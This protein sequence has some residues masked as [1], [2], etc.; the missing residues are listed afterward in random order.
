MITH[1]ETDFY[2]KLY[3]WLQLFQCRDTNENQTPGAPIPGDWNSED[4]TSTMYSEIEAHG[5]H[6][7][8]YIMGHSS[9][10]IY[11]GGNMINGLCRGTSVTK[12]AGI[13]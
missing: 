13:R 10:T 5:I 4:P 7:L 6:T 11:W 2:D 3:A 12:A 1:L 9:P 8:Y